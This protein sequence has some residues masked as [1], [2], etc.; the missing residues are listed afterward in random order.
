MRSA[1]QRETLR[2]LRAAA[3]RTHSAKPSSMLMV[4]FLML[5]SSCFTNFVSSR[6]RWRVAAF[7]VVPRG[8]G[9]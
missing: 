7:G 8:P 1:I 4:T 5:Q 2:P 3:T 9:S 6:N